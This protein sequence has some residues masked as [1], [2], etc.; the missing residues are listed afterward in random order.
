MALKA[1]DKYKRLYMLG[2]IVHNEDVIARLK[3]EGIKKIRKIPEDKTST[4]LLTAHGT[5]KETID[6]LEKSGHTIIDATCPMVKEIHK[7]A[8]EF[9]RKGYPIIVIGDKAHTE[10]IGICG[11]LKRKPLVIEDTEEASQLSFLKKA[12][13]VVQSTQDMEKVT[14]IESILKRKIKELKFFNT[15]CNPTRIKQK[16]I[17]ELPRKN[18]LVLIIGSKNSAN[19]KR[20]YEISLSINKNTYWINSPQDIKKEWLKNIKS[21]GITAGASTPSQKIQ[22]ILDYLNRFNYP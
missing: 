10:V 20:L 15:I 1:K 9:E 8:E 7:I 4:F 13:V 16:E 14:K 2:D 6:K 18:D 3:R 17:K 21:I 5:P 12:C 22:E 11:Q 19:T